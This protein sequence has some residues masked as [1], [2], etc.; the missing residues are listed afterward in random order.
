MIL[1]TTAP[2]IT[3]RTDNFF[4]IKTSF[5]LKLVEDANFIILINIKLITLNK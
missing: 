2:K 1:K 3:K 4:T 5:I